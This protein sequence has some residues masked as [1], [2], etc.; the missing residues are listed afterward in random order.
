[1]YYLKNGLPLISYSVQQW[2]KTNDYTFKEIVNDLTIINQSSGYDLFINDIQVVEG[3]EFNTG[4]GYREI[5]NQSF[6]IKFKRNANPIV[7][8]EMIILFKVYTD[9]KK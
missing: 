8:K 3:D 5:I 2:K 6:Q 1:M 9:L 4:G 7:K